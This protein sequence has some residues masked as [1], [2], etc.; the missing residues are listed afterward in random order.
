[1]H[2]RGIV[3][4]LAQTTDSSGMGDFLEQIAGLLAITAV[5]GVIWVAL[6]VVIAQRAGERRQ[7]KAQGLPP[8]P[9]IFDQFTNLIQR[10]MGQT[11]MKASDTSQPPRPNPNQGNSGMNAALLPDLDALTNPIPEP[12]FDNLVGNAPSPFDDIPLDEQFKPPPAV[13][14]A[15]ASP[16]IRATEAPAVDLNTDDAAEVLRVWRDL[17][18]GNLLIEMKGQVFSNTAEL[19]ASGLSQRYANLLSELSAL[20]KLSIAPAP[21]PNFANFAPPTPKPKAVEADNEPLNVPAQIEAILQKRLSDSNYAGRDIH[22]RPAIDGG[23]LIEVDGQFYNSVDDVPDAD[24]RT[25][26]QAA[27]QTWEQSS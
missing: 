23:V 22:V 10:S 17:I 7:R 6:M 20:A 18:T 2:T 27:I 5:A 12:S 11:P 9:S 4:F 14:S 25:F 16:S 19:Q 15:I 26:I 24:I 21:P 8:P 13:A 1:M 3:I